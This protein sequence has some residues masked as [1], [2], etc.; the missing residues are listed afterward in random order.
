MATAQQM[1]ASALRMLTIKPDDFREDWADDGLDMLNS[2]LAAWVGEGIGIANGG[3]LLTDEMPIDP[4]DELA[5]KSNLA[6]LLST[7]YGAP[8]GLVAIVADKSKRLLQARFEKYELSD[9]PDGIL[10]RRIYDINLS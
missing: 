8:V 9:M 6:V 3:I 1:I 5:I 2:M 4:Q 10:Q 7:E